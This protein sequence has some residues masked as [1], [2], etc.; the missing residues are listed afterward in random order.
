[1][2]WLEITCT[3]DAET[4]EALSEL[5]ARY[6]HGGGIVV[7]QPITLGEDWTSYADDPARPVT[8]R[9]WVPA[10]TAGEAARAE[11]ERGVWVLGMIRPVGELAVRRVAEED[12]A[13]A[14]K[15]HYRIQRIGRRI[16]IVP[17]WL[18]HA[19]EP[20]DVVVRLD[21]GMAFGTGLH[22]TT[23]LCLA[24]L[25]RWL[26]PGAHV[27]DLGTGSGILAI[28]AAG[29][30]AARVLAVDI[31]EVAVRAAEANVAFNT[32]PLPATHRNPAV[33]PRVA[34]ASGRQSRAAT[35]GVPLPIT[36][37]LG[38]LPQPEAPFDL[39]LGNLIAGVIISL[40]DAIAAALKPSAVAILSGIIRD[41]LPGVIEALDRAGLERV[42]EQ[43]AGDWVMLGVRRQ[44]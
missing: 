22:P 43:W 41:R 7:E 40:A 35:A 15:Q 42:D 1:M 23:Q 18:D 37:R 5:F 27:L 10:T 14:W 17:A 36:V 9:T 38:S 30:G 12:W 44:D 3:A 31:D 21:P 2:T 39:L 20:G 24:A 29:L 4:V 19:P 8:V 26:R 25:E 6:G 33:D 32:P 28:A 34:E 11:I 13:N 16:V